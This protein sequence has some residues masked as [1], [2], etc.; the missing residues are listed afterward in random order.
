MST[1][2]KKQILALKKQAHSLKPVVMMGQL[3][4]TPNVIAEIDHSLDIHELIKVKTT[5]SDKAERHAIANEICAQ[6]R[7]TFVTVIGNVAVIY[8]KN[9]RL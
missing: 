2:T 6:T 3:G 5:G 7:S 1:L 9:P 4:L 8:R